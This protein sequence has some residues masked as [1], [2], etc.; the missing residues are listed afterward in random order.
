MPCVCILLRNFWFSAT[1]HTN[2]CVYCFNKLTS[3]KRGMQNNL[4][5]IYTWRLTRH[6]CHN[7]N[8]RHSNNVYPQLRLTA[9]SSEYLSSP[10][11][12]RASHERCACTYVSMRLHKFFLFRQICAFDDQFLG[13]EESTISLKWKHNLIGK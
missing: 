2:A 12:L 3:R 1:A 11:T 4:L 13:E 8:F 6:K 7:S 10:H 9:G 5:V